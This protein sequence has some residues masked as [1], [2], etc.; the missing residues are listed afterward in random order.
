M[1]SPSNQ[2]SADVPNFSFLQKMAEQQPNP[3]N[4]GK[5]CLDIVGIAIGDRGR[6]CHEHPVCGVQLI[7]GSTVRLRKK[8]LLVDGLREVTI[9]VYLV[10]ANGGDGCRVGFAPRHLV[11]H[12]LEYNGA[13]ARVKEV[14]SR[15]DK[16]STIKRRKVHQNH[17]F[18]VARRQ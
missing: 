18:A 16:I 1:H 3:T 14:Y 13:L 5:I 9:A 15:H 10:T 2:L 17:G 4:S 7:E 8:I 12:M 11:K 6:S